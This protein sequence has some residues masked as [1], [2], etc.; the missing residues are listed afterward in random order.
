[1]PPVKITLPAL[2]PN[3]RKLIESPARILYVGAGTKTGKTVG[4]ALWIVQ[5]FLAGERCAVVGPWYRRSRS[6]FDLLKTFLEVPI[7]RQDV[8]AAE[9]KFTGENGG[10]VDFYSGDNPEAIYGDA[11]HRVVI[12]EASRQTEASLTAALTTI[13]ATN[14]KVRLAFNLERGSKN[15]AIRHLLRVKHMTPE[16]RATS[17]EDYM[18]FPTLG[19]G[20]VPAELIESMRNKMPESLWRALYLAEI[21]E[22]DAAL[23][24]GLDE[25]FT[26]AEWSSPVKGGRYVMG[27]DL[28]RKQDWTVLTVLDV[29]SGKVAYVDRF[30]AVAWTVQVERAA[31]LYARYGCSRA[32]VDA[33]GVGDVV[34]EELRKAGLR[35]EGFVFTGPSKKRLIERLVV[36]CEKREISIPQKYVWLREEMD[37][38]EYELSESGEVR[39]GSAAGMSD[40]G[41]MSLALACQELG[42]GGAGF[43][44]ALR[45]EKYA[46]TSLVDESGYRDGKFYENGGQWARDM[47]EAEAE[48]RDRRNRFRGF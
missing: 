26:G 47:D 16:E 23:L 6:L 11:Y 3:Q 9:L 38:M 39:Y 7:A 2:T 21:P 17:S 32:V 48:E 44:V 33:T 40:D 27:A 15:W 46:G 13:S 10:R 4:L 28:A 41:V 14:G 35:V 25:I 36:A 29:G 31:A 8:A 22:A 5:G 45:V 19:E 37:A 12:D 1:M 34:I 20:F 43:F 24:R 30:N 18:L 42:K